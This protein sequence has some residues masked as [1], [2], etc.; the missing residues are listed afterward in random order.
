MPY[1]KLLLRAPRP[2]FGLGIAETNDKDIDGPPSCV[3]CEQKGYTATKKKATSPEKAV[4]TQAPARSIS[5]TLSYVRK[6]ARP[7]SVTPAA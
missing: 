1:T 2:G 5:S 6:V 3:L 4:P 7:R